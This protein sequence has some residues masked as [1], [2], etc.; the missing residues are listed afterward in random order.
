[1]ARRSRPQGQ[2]PPQRLILDAA[3]VI[4]LSRGERRLRALLRHALEIGM[5]IRIPVAILAETLRGGAQDAPVHRVRNAVAVFPTE[6]QTGRLAGA[7]LGATGGKNT[8]DALVAAEAVLS[9]ADVLTGDPHDLR[10][11]LARYPAVRIIPL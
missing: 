1:V 11:L 10:T 8:V 7:M 4:A 6:E 5:D 2:V 9:A 3:A